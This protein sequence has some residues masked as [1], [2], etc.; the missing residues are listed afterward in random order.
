M[1][2]E[3]RYGIDQNGVRHPVCDDTRVD[4]SSYAV[5]G[6]KNLLDNQAVSEGNFTVNE[7]KTITV[8]GTFNARTVLYIRSKLTKYAPPAGTYNLLFSDVSN[9]FNFV[10]DA[11]LGDTWVKNLATTKTKTTFS[12]DYN[13][14]DRVVVFMVIEASELPATFTN[15]TFKPMITVATDTDFTYAPPTMTNTELTDR[16]FYKPGDT[17]S[18]YSNIIFSGII[19][20]GAKEI[21]LTIPFHKSLERI[22]GVTFSQNTSFVARG[23]SGYVINGGT[24]ADYPCTFVSKSEG[25]LA[26]KV[27]KNDDTAFTEE[28]NTPIGISIAGTL[29]FS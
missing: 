7:N 16:Q 23:I 28:N 27:V 14:Y 25:F 15:V 10:V 17:V 3:F 12:V 29:I 24:I 19:T 22:S 5:L 20:G 8:N 2:N 18:L 4:W 11:Y 26:L 6:A 13:G 9:K 21:Y 1:A